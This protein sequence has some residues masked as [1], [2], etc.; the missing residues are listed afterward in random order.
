M[1]G[2]TDVLSHGLHSTR[3]SKSEKVKVPFFFI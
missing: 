1:I 2:G 3:V